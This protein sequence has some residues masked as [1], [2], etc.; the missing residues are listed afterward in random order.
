MFLWYK[1]KDSQISQFC[2]NWDPGKLQNYLNEMQF[3]CC[4]VL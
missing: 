3:P 1:V 2:T 4:Q